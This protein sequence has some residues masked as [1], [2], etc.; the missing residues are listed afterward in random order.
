MKQLV[1]KFNL[2]DNEKKVKNEEEFNISEYLRGIVIDYAR[3]RG[4]WSYNNALSDLIH[5][6]TMLKNKR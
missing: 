6:L 4:G 3:K 2:N 5:Q 1:E